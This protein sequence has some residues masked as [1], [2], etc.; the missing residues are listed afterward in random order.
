MTS[1]ISLA[2][3]FAF[4]NPLRP[5]QICIVTEHEL[6]WLYGLD[7]SQLNH[8]PTFSSP[9]TVLLV[10]CQGCRANPAL[11]E[12]CQQRSIGLLELTQDGESV[13]TELQSRLPELLR[14]RKSVHGVFLAVK[15]TGVLL[16]GGSGIGK[17]EVALD[18]VQR[19]HQLIADDSVQIYRS[20]AG[21]LV[22]EC[23]SLLS[24]YIEIRGLGFI[25]MER[26]FG[27]SSVLDQYPLQMVIRFRDVSELPPES[28]DRM[29]ADLTIEEML[30]VEIPCLTMMVAPGRNLSVLV[31]AAVRDHLLRASGFDGSM[32][33]VNLHSEMIADDSRQR[34]NQKS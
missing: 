7:E 6:E 5:S 34:D 19:G 20:P 21:G 30:G 32:E 8:S 4:I 10:L 2:S 13:Y 24:G 18:L 25:N 29:K 27:P 17:S 1:H 26:M 16:T 23:P 9:D 12:V 3:I 31:E 15:N 11:R 22:G 33:F 28:I 14:E